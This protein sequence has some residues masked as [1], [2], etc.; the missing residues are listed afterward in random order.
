VYLFGALLSFV[1]VLLTIASV[2]L[3]L[4]WNSITDVED[5]LPSGQLIAFLLGAGSFL[6]TLKNLYLDIRRITAE[7][8]STI[9]ESIRKHF[10]LD[11]L[12]DVIAM[13]GPVGSKYIPDENSK[14]EKIVKGV[15]GGGRRRR[16]VWEEREIEEG[17]E[18]SIREEGLREG[19]S[20]DTRARS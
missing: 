17:S 19:P 3:T 8:G 13:T 20:E 1:G 5:I 9:K 12:E 18:V 14:W 7:E 15:T 10:G 16:N 6:Q 2:E 11:V 4:D